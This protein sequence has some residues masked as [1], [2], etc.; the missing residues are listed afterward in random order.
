[1][2]RR[3]IQLTDSLHEYL[4][5]VSLREPEILLRL[6]EETARDRRARMQISPEQGQFMALLVRLIDAR[7]CLEVGVFT[8]YSSL[9]V[10]LSLPDDGRIVACDVN[11][12]WTSVARRYWAE[13]RVA[14]KVELRL[15]PAL[16]TLDAMLAAGEAGRFDFAFIDADKENYLGYYERVLELLRRGGV[17]LVDNT[18]WSGRVADPENAESDTVAL[19]HFNE[20]VHC[21]ERV[22]LSVLPMGDGLTLARKR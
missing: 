11:E 3:T 8:G 16:E 7:R 12:R 20:H 21:D 13:A 2:S 18:L 15:A 10:A 9:A 6:R 1:M 19:R 17:L 5:S 4:L 22:D 14:H